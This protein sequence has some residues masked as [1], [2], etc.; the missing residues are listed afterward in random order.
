GEDYS[1]I[2]GFFKQY[3]LVYDFG[4]QRDLIRV[5]TNYREP[6]EDTYVY[7]LHI[8]IENTR[9]VFLDYVRKINE[10]KTRPAFYNTLSTNCTTSIF[11]HTRVN[12]GSPPFRLKGLLAG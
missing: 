11:F 10:L 7:R 12:P 3:E 8:P 6:K 5:R 2:A 9:R 1:T 4:D